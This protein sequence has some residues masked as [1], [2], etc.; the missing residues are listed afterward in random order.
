MT[1]NQSTR[2]LNGLPLIDIWNYRSKAILKP[3]PKTAKE[4]ERGKERERNARDKFLNRFGEKWNGRV[5]LMLTGITTIGGWHRWVI[6]RLE[7]REIKREEGNKRSIGNIKEEEK[8]LE[9]SEEHLQTAATNQ[10]PKLA[11]VSFVS[12]L[13][14][15]KKMINK[16]KFLWKPWE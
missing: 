16:N 7:E 15:A 12:K 5:M 8:H 6:G 10:M 2:R 3:F 14:T 1:W 13:L 11:E 4:R 9:Q